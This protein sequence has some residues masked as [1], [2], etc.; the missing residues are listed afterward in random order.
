[1]HKRQI[2]HRLGNELARMRVLLVDRH[3][4]ARN[5]MRIIL[6][7]LGITAVH[8]AGT[9][10]EVLRQ[11]KAYTFDIILSDYQDVYKRQFHWRPIKVE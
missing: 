11:V 6:S 7:S 10:A 2:Q 1:M 4:S 9:S 3:A 5:S 8:N